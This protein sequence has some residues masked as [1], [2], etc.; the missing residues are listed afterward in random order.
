MWNTSK[1]HKIRYL[2]MNV[3]IDRSETET[4]E[5]EPANPFTMVALVVPTGSAS[6][7][8]TVIFF[9]NR[10]GQHFFIRPFSPS[11]PDT[12]GGRF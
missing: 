9:Q 1:T 2:L 8:G 7:H 10:V 12:C 11:R 4:R 3:A 6:I 5:A